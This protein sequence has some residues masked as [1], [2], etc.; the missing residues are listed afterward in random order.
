MMRKASEGIIV[1]LPVR[2]IEAFEL[3]DR[4]EWL[5]LR[6]VG[7]RRQSFSVFV[8]GSPESVQ[9]FRAECLRVIDLQ[10]RGAEPRLWISLSS[11]KLR[12]TRSTRP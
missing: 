9:R 12:N 7:I 4:N 2:I 11:A 6:V 10:A 3:Q 5:D 1:R 8:A